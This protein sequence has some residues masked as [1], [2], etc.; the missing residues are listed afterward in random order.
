M[1]SPDAGQGL[2]DVDEM[3]TFV[4]CCDATV[5]MGCYLALVK[6]LK[7]TNVE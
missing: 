4:R 7:M 2:T 5:H 6:C 3:S 1:W